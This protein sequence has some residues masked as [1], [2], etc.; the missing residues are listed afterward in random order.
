MKIVIP[1][2][3]KRTETQEE[4]DRAKLEVS[5]TRAGATEERAKEIASRIDSTTLETTEEIRRRVAE[6][7]RKTDAAIAERYERTRNLAAKKAMEAVMGTVKLHAET[8]KTLG[9]NPGDS[10]II[11]HRGNTH[12]LRAE[13]APIEA[14]EMH[15]HERDLEKLGATEGTRLATRR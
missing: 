14:R 15:L 1:L 5:I 12:T 4:F 11:E 9:A 3:N 10:I 8:M 2:V 13:T 6:E 7:L